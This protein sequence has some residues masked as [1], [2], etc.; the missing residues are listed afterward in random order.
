[1]SDR[2]AGGKPWMPRYRAEDLARFD[3]DT[4]DLDGEFLDRDGEPMSSEEW[5]EAK[6]DLDY[7]LVGMDFVG[8]MAIATSWIGVHYEGKPG[9]ENVVFGTQVIHVDH[10]KLARRLAGP[11]G[12]NELSLERLG[13]PFDL[14]DIDELQIGEVVARF[15][16]G[17]RADAET[18]HGWVVEQFT[19]R[20]R[21]EGL[22][23]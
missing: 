9:W 3:E 18:G 16:W 10:E 23:E 4:T 5:I 12:S 14:M 6:A 21:E 1:M 13:E 7:T 15:A 19:T 8:P 17:S 20:F 22:I 2:E 11:P